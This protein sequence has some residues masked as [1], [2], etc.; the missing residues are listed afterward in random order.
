MLTRKSTPEHRNTTKHKRIY[1]KHKIPHVPL[2]KPIH[3]PPVGYSSPGAR[4]LDQVS[5]PQ[6]TPRCPVEQTPMVSNALRHAMQL[7]QQVSIVHSLLQRLE[8]R[9][10]LTDRKQ[11]RGHGTGWDVI[12]C[13]EIYWAGRRYTVGWDG[14]G[15]D[16]VG[17]HRVLR[18]GFCGRGGRGADLTGWDEIG[19]IRRKQREHLM[20]GNIASSSRR[21]TWWDKFGE[22]G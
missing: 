8:Q 4:V 19:Q 21:G 3:P 22:M 14:K 15:W 10:H 20:V 17:K 2:G 18:S 16:H 5:L 6:K 12:G 13:D 1:H 9:V 7:L 11:F